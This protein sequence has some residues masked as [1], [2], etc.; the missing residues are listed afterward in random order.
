MK[1]FKKLP[2]LIQLILLIIPGVNWFTELFIRITALL[3]KTNLKNLVGLVLGIFIPVFFGWV[4]ALCL[5]L[6][7]H[8]FLD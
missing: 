8:L 5:V 7:N 1:I 4:D 3:D 2:R 6:Y